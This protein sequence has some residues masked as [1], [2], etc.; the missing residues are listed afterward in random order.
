MF[1]FNDLSH[2]KILPKLMDD[3]LI[4]PDEFPVIAFI[5]AFIVGT[6]LSIP[7]KMIKEKE[8]TPS[9][10]GPRQEL[11]NQIVM[12]SNEKDELKDALAKEREHSG[13]LEES[14]GQKEQERELLLERFREAAL[15]AGLRGVK[16]R[17]IILHLAEVGD[18]SPSSSDMSL[19]LIHQE[20]LLNIT[21]ELWAAGA[22]AMAIG[23]GNKLER[24]VTTTAIRCVGPV[25]QV[26]NQ[27][28]A[29]P[30]E[31]LA[32]G[33]PQQLRD[34]LQMPGGVLQPLKYFQITYFIEE[35]DEIIL[36]PYSGVI[37]TTYTQPL[38]ESQEGEKK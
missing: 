24:I 8:V 5:L 3:S 10:L 12:L 16:G 11:I 21:N 18:I 7:F 25:V 22:E 13:K 35:K 33:D 23:S 30:Y 1:S 32:I 19:Y 36:P 6:T 34:A 38:E 17:G 28:M 37:S 15:L 9:M 20:D 27:S 29:P 31:I 2:K 14:Y 26:N 4:H